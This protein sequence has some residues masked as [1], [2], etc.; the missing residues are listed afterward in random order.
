MCIVYNILVYL[1]NYGILLNRAQVQVSKYQGMSRYQLKV[2]KFADYPINVLIK[3]MFKCCFPEWATYALNRVLKKFP[4]TR[5]PKR[6]KWDMQLF[7]TLEIFK[8]KG[9]YQPNRAPENS[10][11]AEAVL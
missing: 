9:I 1:Y 11:A 10:L 6:S 2:I 5:K 7:L 8:Q 3:G 4:D